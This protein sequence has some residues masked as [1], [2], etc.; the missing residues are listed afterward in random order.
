MQ[1]WKVRKAL[2][3]EAR[4]LGDVQAIGKGPRAMEKR[5]VRRMMGRLAGKLLRKL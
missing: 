4:V 2:Y 1:L 3:Q 5:V